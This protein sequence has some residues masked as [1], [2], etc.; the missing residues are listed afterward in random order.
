MFQ[1]KVMAIRHTL[2]LPVPVAETVDFFAPVR[3]EPLDASELLI[4]AHDVAERLEAYRRHLAAEE[5]RRQA[6]R[7]SL[8]EK[9]KK[10]QAEM[11]LPAAGECKKFKA[12][13]A[14]AK[15]RRVE[16]VETPLDDCIA[17]SV[18]M[19][20]CWPSSPNS[21]SNSTTACPQ[22]RRCCCGCMTSSCT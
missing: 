2:R 5:A 17:T 11:P 3:A 18:R 9:C 22:G 6:S 12:S 19:A 14:L 13:S 21:P 8:E 16:E 7:Q 10:R 20:T 1:R 15:Q 4:Y